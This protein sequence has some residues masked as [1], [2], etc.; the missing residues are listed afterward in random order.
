MRVQPLIYTA[1]H[2]WVLD[3]LKK[4]SPLKKAPVRVG[5][6]PTP[7]EAD[8]SLGRTQ[9]PGEGTV[10][11]EA[12]SSSSNLS[13]E[14]MRLT[15]RKVPWGGGCHAGHCSPED[16]KGGVLAQRWACEAPS[17]LHLSWSFCPLSVSL[18]SS[19]VPHLTVAFPS[20]GFLG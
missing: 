2:R 10:R 8:T 3:S 13:M 4:G 1:Q 9:G 16:G 5:A 6:P 15:S 18:P 20:L 17:L 14:P 19:N 7:L 11:P 12:S